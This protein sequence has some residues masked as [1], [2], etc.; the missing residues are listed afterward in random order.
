MIQLN[1]DL[2]AAPRASSLL[3]VVASGVYRHGLQRVAGLIDSSPS[4]LS[5]ALSGQ[6]RR[7]LGVPELER[8]IEQTGDA[9]PIL[10][11]IQK[12]LRTEESE[13]L[14]RAAKLS[15]FSQQMAELLGDMKPK[16]K[17]GGK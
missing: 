17:R 14:E 7:K 12:F 6:D 3:E 1:L 5:E 8:Y 4:H 10:Y 9:G 2:S 15:A 13:Q 11:L 16:A